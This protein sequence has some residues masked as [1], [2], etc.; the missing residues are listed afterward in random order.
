MRQGDSIYA[1]GAIETAYVKKRKGDA[2]MA[3]VNIRDAEASCYPFTFHLEESVKS[4]HQSGA[5][6]GKIIDA[7]YDG[8][9]KERLGGSYTVVY[10]VE[11][12]DGSSLTTNEFGLKKIAQ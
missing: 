12:A 5:P 9:P 3:R 7:Y 11:F 8:T 4:L 6:R 10:T 2:S 1:I